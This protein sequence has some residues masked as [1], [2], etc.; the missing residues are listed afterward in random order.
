LRSLR[1]RAVPTPWQLFEWAIVT[2]GLLCVA[3]VTVYWLSYATA[4]TPGDTNNYILAGLRLNVGHLLYSY[5]PG[6][7]H[8]LATSGGAD[9]A[10]FSPPLIAV[11]F[12]LIVL[13]PANG[14]Y[15][16]WASMDV[17]E[18][19]AILALVRR[20]PFAT[21]LALIPLCLSIG[22]VMEVGNVD[23]LV[24]AGLLLAW[25]QLVRGHDDRAAVI[26]AVLA[27]LKLTPVIFVW[28]LFVTGRRRAAGIAIGCGIAL[29]FVAMLGSE[30]LIF[31]RFYEVTMANLS[32]PA[33]DLGPPGLARTLG[34]PAIVV[35]WLPRAILL[36]G[37]AAMW[38]TRHRPGVSW[39]I[40][41]LLMWLASPVI[42]LHTL[43]LALA[44]I[45]PLAWPMVS[46]RVRQ[47]ARGDSAGSTTANARPNYNAGRDEPPRAAPGQGAFRT[48]W[49]EGR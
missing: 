12:R 42:A 49:G 18:L 22:L 45:A 28:W 37:A 11:V 13:L 8:A 21:G 44:A 32:A 39:A 30:P 48:K 17:L 47:G 19:L 40:G 38:A 34:L 20:A 26:I 1:A 2:I 9:Y 29:A 4:Q 15:L 6:D 41:A 36:G 16:W 24:L 3:F 35:A 5:S 14:R 27:S 33:S 46:G 31:A 25:C 23:C 7:A 43:A 10:I